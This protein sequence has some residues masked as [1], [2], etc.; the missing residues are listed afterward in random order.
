MSP[1][2]LL[3]LPRPVSELTDAELT[4][5]LANYFPFTRPSKPVNYVITKGTDTV[6]LSIGNNPMLAKIRAAFAAE[7]LDEHGNPLPKQKGPSL[8]ATLAKLKHGQQ[9]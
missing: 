5:H 2:E 4:A 1:E 6:D 8:N 7:G 3:N 9:K